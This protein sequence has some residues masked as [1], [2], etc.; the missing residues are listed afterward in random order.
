MV[1][2]DG[3][4]TRQNEWRLIEYSGVG[5]AMTRQRKS[6]PVYWPDVLV[7]TSCTYFIVGLT[8]ALKLAETCSQTT[9]AHIQI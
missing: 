6:L 3:E 2:T 7:V 9:A 5:T 8:I 1:Y 4:T